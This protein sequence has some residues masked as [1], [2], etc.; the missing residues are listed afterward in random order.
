MK[1]LIIIFV[2]AL[3]GC[4]SAPKQVQLQV[5]TPPEISDTT[6]ASVRGANNP[7]TKARLLQLMKQ[8]AIYG[9]NQIPAFDGWNVYK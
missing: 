9:P 7:A 1:K 3:V 2:L 8:Q 6:L 4:A 5:E